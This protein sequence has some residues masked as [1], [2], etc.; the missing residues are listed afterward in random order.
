VDQDYELILYD[1]E[2]TTLAKSEDP[3][4]GQPGE[5][6]AEGLVYE[7]EDTEIYLLSIENYDGQARGDAIFDLFI[8]EGDMHPD[9]MVAEGSLSS[10][11]DARGAFAVGAVNWA[12]DVLE[13]YSSQGPTADGRIKPD[14]AAPSVVDTVSYGPEA[15][16]GTSAAA[17][18]VS[19]AAALILQ[20]HPG[21]SPDEIA[22]L[23]QD[24]ALDLGPP[25]PDNRFG[26]GRLSLGT[27][28][29]NP[30][31]SRG[32]PRPVADAQATSTG[33]PPEAAVG[34]PGPSGSGTGRAQ[35]QDDGDDLAGLLILLGFCFVCLGAVLFVGVLVVGLLVMR[36]N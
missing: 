13:A 4:S 21:S 1:S 33:R 32:T 2:G 30:D 22:M 10:P 17:P 24:R 25:G 26:V 9:F 15:F 5:M 11:S 3:Q 36:R 20:A 12:D 14:L 6:P 31:A 8:H 34:L 23:L 28:P 27:A 16:D 19:G 35:A 18:H 7:F 29:D